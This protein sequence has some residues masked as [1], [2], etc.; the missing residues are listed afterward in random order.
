MNNQQIRFEIGNDVSNASD[1]KV[2]ALIKSTRKNSRWSSVL[3]DD[4]GSIGKQR[5][6]PIVCEVSNMVPA[7]FRGSERD[8]I[9]DI[10]M[11]LHFLNEHTPFN[12]M[13]PLQSCRGLIPNLFK[14]EGG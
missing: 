4:S 12:D 2:R 6:G 5:L 11:S 10:Y 14:T 8:K 9:G 7:A 13:A 1:E 3:V